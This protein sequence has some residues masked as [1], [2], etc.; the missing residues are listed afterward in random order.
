VFAAVVNDAG[1]IT[2]LQN[3]RASIYLLAADYC[4]ATIM[5]RDL[6]VSEQRGEFTNRGFVAA[7]E[8]SLMI[9]PNLARLVIL[10]PNKL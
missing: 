3:W 1:N 6:K 2:S 8:P 7:T 5:Q 10:F 9:A 4:V